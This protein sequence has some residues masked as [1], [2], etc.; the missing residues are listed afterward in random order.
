MVGA[1][2]IGGAICASFLI[3]SVKQEMPMG[4]F[5]FILSEMAMPTSLDPLEADYSNNLHA[6]QMVHNAL[7]E[8]SDDNTLQ[9]SILE[10]FSYDPQSRQIQFTLLSD[11]KFSDGSPI[12]IEDVEITIR[13]MM[14]KRPTFPV[15]RHIEGIHA[16][17]NGTAPLTTRPAGIQIRG[18]TLIVQL[19]QDVKNPL[20]R[21]AL[22]IYGVVKKDCVDLKTNTLKPNCPTSGFY[23]LA[24]T[25]G[26]TLSFKRSLNVASRGHQLADSIDLIYQNGA[27]NKAKLESLAQSGTQVI[28]SEESSAASE[29]KTIQE[30]LGFTRIEH[31]NARF[32]VFLLN[33]KANIFSNLVCRQQFASVFR[34]ELAKNLNLNSTESSIFNRII[35]GYMSPEELAQVIT[36]NDSDRNRCLEFF[37]GQDLRWMP[38]ASSA[39]DTAI[40]GALAATTKR[41]NLKLKIV[42]EKNRQERFDDFVHNKI[43]L[44]MAGSG[45]WA[46]DPVGDV[47]MLF[48]PGLHKP[49]VSL[50]EDTHLQNILRGLEF[51]D[52]PAARLK[53]VNE[54]LYEQSVFNVYAHSK[55]V[56]VVKGPGVSKSIPVAITPPAPWQVFRVEKK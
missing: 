10:S 17:A 15:L 30:G 53:K 5:S 32:S 31:P 22:P 25:A 26:N 38:Q 42:P 20:F 55:R 19:G 11:A 45:F 47:Q 14:A 12:T 48:T 3:S 13:R 34:Q 51:E 16:W 24:E 49:L 39:S 4:G 40:H 52:N 18:N 6:S 41:L 21:F 8:V 9:S 44:L 33:P 29:N 2:T 28:F 1:I 56:Y 36:P 27:L 46:F 7:L 37:S 54:Y 50:A 43:D 35:P 23:L